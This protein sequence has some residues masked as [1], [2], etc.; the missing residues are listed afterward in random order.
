MDD[1]NITMEEY[2]RL[3]EEKAQKHGKVY[4]WETA[5]YGK[6]W[7]DED[8]LDLRSIETEFPAIVCNDSFTSNETPSCEP[9]VSSLNNNEI[10][11]RIS[12]DESEDEDYMNE[13][14]AIVYNDALM[15]KSDFSTEP[16]LCPQH[17]DKF[18][19]KDETLLYEYDKVEQS[20]LYFNNLF[21]FNIFYPDDQKSDKGNDE[22]EINMIQSS[23]SNENT[24]RLLK[25]SHNKIRKVFI[26]ECFIMGLNVNIVA[27][28]HFVNRMLFNLIKNLY[29][30]FGIP[31]NPK[32]YYK[33]GDCARV[34]RRPRAEVPVKIPPRRNRPLTEAYEQEFEQHGSEGEESENPFFEGGGSSYEEQPDRPRRNQR[35]DNRHWK[36]R[37]RVNILEFD[38]NT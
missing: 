38:G 16:T 28:N 27:W 4:N 13:F 12:F 8:V 26:M 34:L 7:Y 19:S 18:D 5:K 29:V 9:T 6:I 17:S 33:D 1:Q 30:L 32:R 10:D 22:N 3:E 23:G 2:I 31:F 11:F 35:E 21:P 24:N 37:M 25:E 36:S 14:S 15:S 20:V